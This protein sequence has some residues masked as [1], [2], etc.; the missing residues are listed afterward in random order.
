MSQR[1]YEVRVTGHAPV[2]LVEQVRDVRVTEHELRTVLTG[3]FVDQAE[4]FAF[5]NLLRSFG[6]EVVEVRRVLGAEED[7]GAKG[8]KGDE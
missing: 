4:L 3:S 2:E 7:S 6:L 8:G 1:T 5:V